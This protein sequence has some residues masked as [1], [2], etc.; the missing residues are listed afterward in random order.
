MAI[1]KQK[2]PGQLERVQD[3]AVVWW[4]ATA[5]D[6]E[7][8][9]YL[10]FAFLTLGL[11]E[12]VLP[13]LVLDDWGNEIKALD[14][15]R[16]IREFGDQFPRAELFGYGLNGEQRQHFLRELDL[17]TP[18]PCYV[19]ASANSQLVEAAAVTDFLIDDPAADRVQRIDAPVEVDYP[20]RGAAVRWW[21][22]PPGTSATNVLEKDRNAQ[23]NGETV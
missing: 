21:S 7:P 22:V 18:Y 5:E 17:H 19:F 20:L 2:V 15:Y 11:E 9:V 13:A 1:I 16:W 10:S 3:K 6:P 4:P 14:L 23:S 12:Q 8:V